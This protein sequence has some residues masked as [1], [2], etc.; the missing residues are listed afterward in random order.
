M[1][2]RL[3][4]LVEDGWPILRTVGG[5]T[6][7]GRS[8]G[9]RAEA[10]GIA[11]RASAEI[12]MGARQARQVAHAR[13]RGAPLNDRTELVD[14]PPV[15]GWDARGGGES[16]SLKAGREVGAAENRARGPSKWRLHFDDSSSSFL[17]WEH[18]VQWPATACGKAQH[19]QS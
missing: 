19:T 17:R 16:S 2:W 12:S 8:T 13:G 18:V 9:V 1:P 3:A 7:E 4:A 10:C 6:E 11:L 14:Q 5:V 15:G